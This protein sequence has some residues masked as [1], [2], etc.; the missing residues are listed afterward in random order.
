MKTIDPE[1]VLDLVREVAAVEIVPRFQ[2][3][4]RGEISEKAGGE[5][6]TVADVAAEKALERR[7]T[8]LLPG[9]LVVGEEAVAETPRVIE[10]LRDPDPVWVVDP[11]DGTGNFARGKEN[12]AVQ[13]ALVRGGET[14]G[15]W[16]YAPI[17]E[18]WAMGEHG[19]GAHLDGRRVVID[20]VDLLP[21]ALKGTLHAGMFS[22]P[23]MGRLM[24]QRRSRVDA[25]KSR[26]AASVE[27]LRLLGQEMHFSFFTKLKPWD[28]APGSFLLQ[29]AGGTA[30]FTDTGERYSPL[31][32][33]GEGL[34]LAPD[35]RSWKRLRETLLGQD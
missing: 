15:A 28:H 22:T 23:E 2:S 1:S 24:Q 25:Q 35:E 31:R 17:L 21:S 7:L 29:E 27:Y 5:L 12:F 19:G 4:A 8:A 16:I 26:S 14:L 11:I 13:I 10:R 30:R 34:L 18:R 32:H 3:L 20:P 6:V 9:S 33:E